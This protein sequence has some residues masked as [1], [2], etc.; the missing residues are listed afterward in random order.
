MSRKLRT[1]L[2]AGLIVVLP[3]VVSIYVLVLTFN[4]IDSWFR[5]LVNHLW[6]TAG[7][8]FAGV[9]AL[10]TIGTILLV[11]WL[12]SSIL[13]RRV[14]SLNDWVFSRMPL[15]R[16]VYRTVKQIMDAVLQQGSAAFQQVVMLQYPRPG[17]WALGFVTGRLK[18]EMGE[19]AEQPLISVFIPTTPNPTSGVLIFAPEQ[20][21]VMLSM[22]V[23]DG[24]KLV[25][26][27]GVVAPPGDRSQ[28]PF[29]R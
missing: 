17:L 24:I 16:S 8:S 22:P 27:G 5:A 1:Y 20:E 7:W 3:T 25:I 28:E 14:L 13:G 10:I 9:G 26:S 23:E 4:L 18:G 6:P 29:A 19:Q 15:V 12:T 2:L 11:G 21:L